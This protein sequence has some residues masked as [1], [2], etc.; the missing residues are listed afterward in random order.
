M[1]LTE[2]NVGHDEMG[3]LDRSIDECARGDLGAM[4]SDGEVRSQEKEDGKMRGCACGVGG[5]G[6][7]WFR[8]KA[9]LE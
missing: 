9:A 6:I 3:S 8:L 2:R 1:Q 5:G 4:A 7:F